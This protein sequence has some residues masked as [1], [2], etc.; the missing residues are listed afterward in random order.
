[1][2]KMPIPNTFH[3]EEGRSSYGDVH[4]LLTDRLCSLPQSLSS[5]LPCPLEVQAGD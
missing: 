5:V 4:H 1:M 2:E 3:L